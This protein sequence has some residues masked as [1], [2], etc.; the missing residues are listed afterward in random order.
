SRF[1]ETFV[2]EGNNNE[3]EMKFYGCRGAFIGDW[4]VISN[5]QSVNIDH[6]ATDIE[7]YVGSVVRIPAADYS[8]DGGAESGG[9]P[10]RFFGGSIIPL[11][12]GSAKYVID[13]AM[14]SADFNNPAVL[15]NGVRIE[16]RSDNNGLARI[17]PLIRGRII[18]NDCGILY[19]ESVGGTKTLASVGQYGRLE[20]N[21]C[22]MATVGTAPVQSWI[23][24]GAA[25]SYGES[26][27]I[28]FDSCSGHPIPSQI[29]LDGTGSLHGVAIAKNSLTTDYG[30]TAEVQAAPNWTVSDGWWKWNNWG[31]ENV[32]IHR[33]PLMV[34]Y[35]PNNA[36]SPSTVILPEDAV[37]LRVVGYIPPQGSSAA[38]I[39]YTFEDGDGTDLFTV[40]VGQ[41]QTGVYFEKTPS[42]FATLDQGI[43]GSTTNERTLIFSANADAGHQQGRGVG[44][45]E[46][47]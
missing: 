35:A 3:S 6:Y 23:L 37:I 31:K 13:I 19:S 39:T 26:G 44:Y 40:A 28:I 7:A 47:L 4:L 34:N 18:L 32:D 24:V 5:P 27:H 29:T 8:G 17:A 9:G 45:I 1:G 16:L 33:V 43:I 41:Q 38:A 30:A 20:L 25:G 14:G 21:R 42:D 10:V 15:L 2:F 36:Q 22:G 11:D 12:A 46:Y